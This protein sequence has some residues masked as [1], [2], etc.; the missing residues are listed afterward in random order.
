[1]S[2]VLELVVGLAVGTLLLAVIGRR[3]ALL[4]WV[5]C[6]EALMYFGL[7]PY[8]HDVTP[9]RRAST[10]SRAARGDRKRPLDNA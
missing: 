9:H 6:Q 8:P 1:M 7:L 5:L 10:P 3:V 2:L 4:V